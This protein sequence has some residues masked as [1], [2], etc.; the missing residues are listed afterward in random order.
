MIVALVRG[1]IHLQESVIAGALH[2][3]QIGHCRH[4]GKLSKCPAHTPATVESANLRCHQG[5][6]VS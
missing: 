6:L 4:F 2:I 5:Y 1:D 3:N